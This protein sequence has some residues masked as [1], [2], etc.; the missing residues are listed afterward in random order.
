MP[1][2]RRTLR[3][4][5][6]S[7]LALLVLAALLLGGGAWWLWHSPEAARAVV[8]RIPG[9]S[10]TKPQGRLTGGPY[11]AERLAWTGSGLRIVVEG[12]AWDD[13]RWTWRPSP[14]QWVGV[15]LQ[16]A[17]AERVQVTRIAPAPAA[18][19]PAQPPASLALPAALQA[20]ALRIGRI[21]LFDQPPITALQAD[22]HL[23][24]AAGAEHR[25][26]GLRLQRQGLTL[27]GQARIG[28]AGELPLSATIEAATAPDVA[29]PWQATLQASGPLQ[30][31]AVEARV[32]LGAA[33]TASPSSSAP[34][35]PDTPPRGELRVQAKLAP[36]ARWPWL[37]LAAQVQDLDLAA[38]SPGL[39]RTRLSGR[40]DLVEPSA[41]QG[42]GDPLSVDLVLA[43]ALPGRI[44]AGRVPVHTLRLR[45]KG[46]PDDPGTL[47]FETL[48]AELAALQRPALAPPA[49]S[50]T[51]R[52]RLAAAPPPVGDVLQEAGRIEGGGRWQ[53]GRLTIDLALQALRPERLHG[54][55]PAMQ[56]DGRIAAQLDGLAPPA[57]SASAPARAAAARPGL[58]GSATLDV[59]GRLPRPGAPPLALQ[60][61][62]AFAQAGDGAMRLTLR[63]AIARAGPQARA[64]AQATLERSAAQAWHVTGQGE[65][66]R[67]DPSTWWPAAGP[68]RGPHS[69][70]GRWNA[71]LRWNGAS[72]L[73]FVD[74]LLG[75]ARFALADS[76]WAGLPWLGEAAVE[77][78]A[79]ALQARADLQAGPNRLQG[80]GSLQRGATGSAPMQAQLDVQAPQL[81]AFAPLAAL[82]PA[83]AGAWWPTAGA[84]TLSASAEGRWPALR[85]TGRLR[86]EGLRSPSLALAEAE[87]RW[88]LSFASPEA[89]LDL[90][91]VASG[92]AS[93]AQRLDRLEATLDGSVRSHRLAVTASSPLRPP[94]WAEAAAG[95]TTS[96]GS[97]FELRGAG[98]WMPAAAGGGT[99]RGT[100]AELR[101]V[102]RVQQ[103]AATAGTAV[104]TAAA[105]SAWLAARDLQATVVLAPG[106][107]PRSA[108]LAPGRIA[109]LGG[110]LAWQQA[111]WQ[112]GAS[113]EAPP[114]MTLRATLDPVAVA[115]WL[116][117]FQPQLGWQGDLAVGGT[118]DVRSAGRMD[119]DIVV[120]RTGGD[121]SLSI[122]G[123]RRSLEL[124]DLRVGLAAHD[125]LWE[126]TQALVGRTVGVVGGLQSIRTSP[127]ALWPAPSAPLEGGLS[128]IVPELGVWAPWLPPGWRLGGNLRVAASFGGRVGAP[129][130]RGEI[131]AEDMTVRNLF[132]GIHL[133]Q[134][135]LAVALTGTDA[136]IE[137]FEFRD[138]PGTGRLVL[139]GGAS[140][141]E[142]PRATLRATAERLRALD[143]VDRR[144]TLSGA[145]DLA[146]QGQRLR[147]S[148]GFAIDEGLIDISQ[149]D[150][151]SID[152]DVLVVNRA[153]LRPSG[154]PAA[155]AAVRAQAAS[156]TI[157]ATAD[158]P[159]RRAS[160]LGAA[161]VDLR[162]NLGEALRLRGRGLDTT[163]RG[164][165]R[166]TTPEGQLAIVGEIDA[167]GGTYT[168]YGQNLRIERGGLRFTGNVA[169]PV[170]DIL[171]LRADIDTR[172][173]VVVTG[174][175]ANP[176]VRLYSEP[177]LGE[178]D[179]LTWL[180]LGRA[181]EGLG[182][183]DT[184]LLQRAA[185]ALLAGERG[186]S[187][188]IQRLGLDELSL[189]RGASGGASDTIVT[190]GKQISKR[191][192]IGYEQA[193]GAA[194]GTVQLIY[195]I[196][197]RITLRAR[198]G[199]ENAI[200]AVWTWRWD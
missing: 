129:E 177:D 163:L 147:A 184:A 149:A 12:L 142:T 89:P 174:S 139:A 70:N 189:R 107:S 180:L 88:N 78:T 34:P 121:L 122:E 54:A 59:A 172:V 41:A 64:T 197:G 186:G 164:Q 117:R 62:A 143:R 128:L 4:V 167:S 114:R 182:R 193:L 26:E 25:V 84:M 125:G 79:Q 188:L 109:A 190:L 135:V 21:E 69:L 27:T 77:A 10:I 134:G 170:L 9:L 175:V 165:L 144:V 195:R 185:L 127:Q 74:R 108:E 148:G 161:D 112:A 196:A 140:F 153:P 30:R 44:D 115:P 86:A 96:T 90:Q 120:Q 137:R 124:S 160:P 73:P 42:S 154:T 65:L 159:A 133:R 162:V 66:Q 87:A 53:A 48:V 103:A 176:R 22:L 101:A 105:G 104:V 113:A 198:T 17:R 75:S 199:S 29:Q 85:S 119:A 8:E 23:G 110:G 132:E 131:T 136:R 28:T 94:E 171:A 183:D 68:G 18:V 5:L 181:P 60:A 40:A 151:P 57:A 63:D 123:A 3:T 15:A 130:Y 92:L 200:D 47:E 187:G 118:I 93:G 33:T 102:P 38:L 1:R 155:V 20:P 11:A 168:A 50:S 13:A 24:A 36:F 166:V 55:A 32:R 98:Q 169:T 99:W 91:L 100:V 49:T 56:L 150:A 45:L 157:A 191:L 192:F 52:G 141:G 152:S 126:F 106:G 16:G 194:G 35:A 43:N 97:R 95:I 156:G 67:F 71:D 19:Q 39:P 61:K 158:A 138:G 6:L 31:P 72:T 2:G 116:A 146:L 14:G 7:L 83:S 173:G 80:R 46:R 179:T 145:A 76:L 51:S 81:A 37:S 111:T 82:L 178:L 58:E